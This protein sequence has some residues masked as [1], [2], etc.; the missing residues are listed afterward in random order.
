VSTYDCRESTRTDHTGQPAARSV[1][2]RYQAAVAALNEQGI[3]VHLD[4]SELSA[5]D[6]WCR[7][8]HTGTDRIA[9]AW[10]PGGFWHSPDVKRWHEGNRGGQ[11]N[12]L[13]FSYRFWDPS[14]AQ[15][16]VNAFTDYG[17]P[18]EWSG[19]PTIR[20]IVHLA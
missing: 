20:V 16:L 3:P 9:V 18:V 8:P 14:V 4:T 13:S 7:Y 2:D 17:F 12:A 5:G 11:V 6:A 19:D 1:R 15:A 10:E